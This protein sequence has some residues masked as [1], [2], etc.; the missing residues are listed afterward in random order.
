MLCAGFTDVML[1]NAKSIIIIITIMVSL[2]IITFYTGRNMFCGM[3]SVCL[4]I[5]LC[6][7]ASIS[8]ALAK[9]CLLINLFH[10]S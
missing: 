6:A 1:P 5:H 8:L 3:L 7:C 9:S 10:L 4:Y 2:S